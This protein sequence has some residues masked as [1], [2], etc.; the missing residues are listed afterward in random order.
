MFNTFNFF[1]FTLYINKKI[2]LCTF[3]H[4]VC[5][6]QKRPERRVPCHCWKLN[7]GHLEEQL[8]LSEATFSTPGFEI[9]MATL[10]S[11]IKGRIGTGLLYWTKEGLLGPPPSCDR[12]GIEPSVSWKLGKHS[13]NEPLFCL[14][15]SSL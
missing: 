4:H 12:L 1:T 3:G 5:A 9:L 7:P 2:C 6:V 14:K 8:V 11:S 10:F 15:N 13:I